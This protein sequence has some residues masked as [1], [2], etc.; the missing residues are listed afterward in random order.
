[1]KVTGFKTTLVDVPFDRPIATAIHNMRSVGC[2]LLEL[3]TDEGLIGESYVFTLNGVR[4]KALHE[5]LLGFAHQVEG[6]DPTRVTAI[7]QAIWD[8]MNPIGHKGFSIAA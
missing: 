5:M 6:K 4:L 2:V 1:M 3:Q 7:G 8:E